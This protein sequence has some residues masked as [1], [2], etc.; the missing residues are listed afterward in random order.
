MSDTDKKFQSHYGSL[1]LLMGPSLYIQRS[2]IYA[3]IVLPAWESV[4]SHIHQLNRI[5]MNY[6]AM[7]LIY[8]GGLLK[9][10]MMSI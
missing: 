10:W 6:Q 9:R 8:V 1:N 2:G 7:I 4:E 5:S 3:V